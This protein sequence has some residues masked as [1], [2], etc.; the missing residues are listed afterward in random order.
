MRKFLIFAAVFGLVAVVSGAL[1]A[2]AFKAKL[3]DTGELENFLR[4]KD[5]MFYHAAA[6]GLVALLVDRFPARRFHWA[7]W[8][9]LAG[10]LL[11]QGSLFIYSLTAEKFLINFTPYGGILLMAGWLLLGIEAWR[12]GVSPPESDQNNSS[13]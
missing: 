4:A 7:G 10:S 6:L 1:A 2:H 3:A 13:A 11:F 5:Y 8:C 12:L 9:F